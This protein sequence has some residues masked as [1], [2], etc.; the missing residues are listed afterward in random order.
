MTKV[1]SLELFELTKSFRVEILPR[2]TVLAGDRFM[3]GSLRMN[4]LRVKQECSKWNLIETRTK[5][6]DNQSSIV[7]E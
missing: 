5:C 3:T 7:K 2:V 1:E 6:T 4:P